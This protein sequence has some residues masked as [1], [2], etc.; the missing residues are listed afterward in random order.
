MPLPQ[1]MDR[2]WAFFRHPRHGI[3]LTVL[4]AVRLSPTM[5]NE[6]GGLLQVVMA[7]A[8]MEVAGRAGLYPLNT[9]CVVA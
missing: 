4:H 1:L 7:A 3:R 8:L 9:C 6:G 2:L 5:W